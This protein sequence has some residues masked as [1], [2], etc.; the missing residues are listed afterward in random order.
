MALGVAAA[1]GCGP[2]VG[3]S[4]VNP[5][6]DLSRVLPSAEQV[7]RA[8][9]SPLDPTALPQV[10]GVDLLPNG[11]RDSSQVSPFD[12]LGAATPLMRVVYARGDVHRVAL[13]DFARYGAGLTVSSAHTGVV[14]FGSEAEAT[15]MF[16]EFVTQWRSCARTRVTVQ[17]TANSALEWTV[18][19][20]RETGSI[21]SAT[22]LNGEPGQET[23]FP[24]E[25]ALGVAADCILEADVA[26]TD[27]VPARREPTGRAAE[28]VSMMRDNLAG[29]R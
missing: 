23:A 13:Q 28:L 1:S 25:H 12:C 16:D 17:I 10:G 4:A 18:T 3:G 2:T 21:L 7:E 14:R 24:T 19:D 20:V 15:R 26:I 27:A 9:G 11:I 29:R 22:V 8:V 6:I 5:Q